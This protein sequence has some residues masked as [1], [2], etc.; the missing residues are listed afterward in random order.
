MSSMAY[1]S[2]GET[3]TRKLAVYWLFALRPNTLCWWAKGVKARERKEKKADNKYHD[4]KSDKK[5]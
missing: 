5:N 4:G 3:W 2:S 1:V